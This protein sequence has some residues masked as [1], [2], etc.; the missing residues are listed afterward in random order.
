MDKYVSANHS[1]IARK[2]NSKT[3][4]RLPK[5]KQE[6]HKSKKGKTSKERKSCDKTFK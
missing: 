3:K 6:K 2:E 1:R 4:H 5:D